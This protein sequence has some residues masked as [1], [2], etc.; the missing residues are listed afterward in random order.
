[1]L[2]NRVTGEGT[3]KYNSDCSRHNQQDRCDRGKENMRLPVEYV[4]PKYQ[5]NLYQAAFAILQDFADAQD[6]VQMVFI[7]Y[8]RLNLDYENE[9]HIRRW[10]FRSALNQAKDIRRSFWRKNQTEL[11]DDVHQTAALYQD[12]L[13]RHLFESVSRL[14]EK[15]RVMLQLFY[16]EEFSIR[17]IAEVTALS[18]AAVK[19]RLSRGRKMLREMLEKEGSG[20]V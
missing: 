16:Y 4:V 12:P 3:F 18:E 8:H 6:A 2:L 1:M 10:L 15:Y 19:K 11:T 17:E 20:D 7:K 5:T 9:D 14:P 13:D